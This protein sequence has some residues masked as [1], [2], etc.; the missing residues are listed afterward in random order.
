MQSPISARDSALSI[1]EIL[2]HIFDQLAVPITSL[3]DVNAST[4]Y[5]QPP[6]QNHNRCY[7]CRRSDDE[8]VVHPLLLG[9]EILVR[10]S[11]LRAAALCCQRF[12]RPALDVLWRTMNSLFPLISLLPFTTVSSTLYLRLS[13]C[14]SNVWDTFIAYANRIRTLVVEG[15]VFKHATSLRL[16]PSLYSALLN[17]RHYLLPSLNTLLISSLSDHLEFDPSLLVSSSLNRLEIGP[18]TG[19]PEALETFIL[20]TLA[21]AGPLSHAAFNCGLTRD[22]QATVIERMASV[23]SLTILSSIITSCSQLSSFQHLRHLDIDTNFGRRTLPKDLSIPLLKKLS[24][25][26]TCP[27]I[28][29]F[30]SILR[31]DLVSLQVSVRLDQ[32]SNQQPSEEEL[33][34]FVGSAAQLWGQ[35]LVHFRLDC[36]QLQHG[37]SSAI[38]SPE[39]GVLHLPK[40]LG[41]EVD[42]YPG[43]LDPS[44]SLAGITSHLPVIQSLVLPPYQSGQEPTL[45]DLRSLAQSCSSLRHLSA[46]LNI[47]SEVPGTVE[48]PFLYHELDTLHVYA[49]PIAD[50]WAVAANLDR[51]FPYLRKVTTLSNLDATLYKKWRQVERELALC[52][53]SRAGFQT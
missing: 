3:D 17:S 33:N 30:L 43:H 8:P 11:A 23:Q 5:R 7:S 41:F 51:T 38:F 22:T 2:S 19:T 12:S 6:H 15:T 16:H 53:R 40:L 18:S 44:A 37:A 21:R 52:H 42:S 4:L 50:P 46:S 27:S 10:K 28:H 36:G 48:L 35:T 34:G 25:H 32:A 45:D 20:I 26:G 47:N 24:V 39:F 49:S 13:E 1:P 14:N 9:D 31:C 29:R